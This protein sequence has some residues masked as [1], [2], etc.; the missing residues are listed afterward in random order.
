M[1]FQKG[2]GGNPRGRPLGFRNR[3]TI[4]AEKLFEEEANA[5]TRVDFSMACSE[6][7]RQ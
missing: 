1:Q 4:V 2:Q 6:C 5:L 3:Q 7:C